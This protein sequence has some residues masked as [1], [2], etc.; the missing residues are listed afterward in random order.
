MRIFLGLLMLMGI[1]QNPRLRMYFSRK[2]LLETPFFPSVMSKE[3]FSLLIKF[4]Q[5]LDNTNEKC[6]YP[7]RKSV[8]PYYC[9]FH[10]NSIFLSKLPVAQGTNQ[11]VKLQMTSFLNKSCSKSVWETIRRGQMC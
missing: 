1:V 5:F 11:A 10:G 6:T 8:N 9:G 4:L 7:V 3:R 2:H